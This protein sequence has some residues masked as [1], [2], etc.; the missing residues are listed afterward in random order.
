MEHTLTSTLMNL[1]QNS[2]KTENIEKSG[3]AGKHSNPVPRSGPDGP[4][5]QSRSP[6]AKSSSLLVTIR[7]K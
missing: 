5:R 4:L 7:R 1:G 2:S 3:K 6:T